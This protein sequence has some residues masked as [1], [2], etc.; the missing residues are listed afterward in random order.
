MSLFRTLYTVPNLR[1]FEARLERASQEERKR[2]EKASMTTAYNVKTRAVLGAPKDKGDLA[3][4]IA[5]QGKGLNWRVGVLDVSIPSRGGS[6]SAHLH[7][8]VYGIWY[9]FGFTSRKIARHAF[10]QPAADAEEG[11][12]VQR[13][14]EALSSAF[15]TVSS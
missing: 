11:P 12:H 15:A 3:N 10:M 8:W 7:P 13:V 1:D 4:N 5:V 14:T 9:E 2:V 6:N